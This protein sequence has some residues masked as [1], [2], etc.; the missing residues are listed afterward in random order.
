MMSSLANLILFIALVTTSI[1]VVVMY[2]RLKR[3][4]QYH[5]EY[6]RIFDK[7]GE[8]L[9]G[10][11]NAVANFGTEGRETLSLLGAR[12]AEAHETSNRLE[13][14]IQSAHELTQSRSRSSNQ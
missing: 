11:Q 13:A 5:A 9:T 6:K 3:L 12:I 1:I 2:R 7:T 10:A 14:L 8:A 4:D